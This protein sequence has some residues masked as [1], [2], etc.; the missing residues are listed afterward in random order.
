MNRL[1]LI[2]VPIQNGVP[3]LKL[4]KTANIVKH[5]GNHFAVEWLGH[6]LSIFKLGML[7]GKLYFIGTGDS[8]ILM[9]LGHL[10]AAVRLASEL[11]DAQRQA[12]LDTGVRAIK[13]QTDGVVVG[14]HPPIVF[15]GDSPIQVGLSG[16]LVD[17][18]IYEIS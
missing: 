5:D 18:E 2:G 12:V 13:R 16:T 9:A 14:I 10:G 11:T 6:Q 1:V 8:Q 7:G 4:P 17:R 15:A 3:D